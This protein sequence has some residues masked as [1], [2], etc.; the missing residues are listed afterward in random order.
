MESMRLLMGWL[1]HEAELLPEAPDHPTLDLVTARAAEDHL[2]LKCGRPA[3]GFFWWIKAAP[4][5]S[6]RA[7]WMDLCPRCCS[8]VW[9]IAQ[10]GA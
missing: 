9:E 3:E 6:D 7:R 8:L 5:T 10:S 4:W 1:A 2:C